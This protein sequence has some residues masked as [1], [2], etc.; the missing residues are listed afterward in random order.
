MG[1]RKKGGG[2]RGEE[3][4]GTR[5]KGARTVRKEGGKGKNRDWYSVSWRTNSATVC[6]KFCNET[7]VEGRSGK[8]NYWVQEKRVRGTRF[9]L[10]DSF[11]SP[12]HSFLPSAFIPDNFPYFD[13]LLPAIIFNTIAYPWIFSSE[14]EE[15][16][17][18]HW[19]GGAAT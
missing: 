5:E 8:Q 18:K 17:S 6:L 11:P 19:F 13:N 4:S 7:E 16:S 15:K 3:G 9:K 10:S 1:T 2:N 12:L 14:K